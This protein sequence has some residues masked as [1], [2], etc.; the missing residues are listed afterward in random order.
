M[1]APLTQGSQKKRANK[2]NQIAKFRFEEPGMTARSLLR[3]FPAD[4]GCLSVKL[5][6]FTSRILH[7]HRKSVLLKGFPA[8]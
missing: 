5:L 1:T 7:L 2:F 3:Q 8:I 4:A 6:L